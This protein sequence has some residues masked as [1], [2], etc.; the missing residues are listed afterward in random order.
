M[1]DKSYVI[2]L[3]VSAEFDKEKNRT[4]INLSK[5]DNYESRNLS[6]EN[7]LYLLS[8]AISVLIKS[9]DSDDLGYKSHELMEMAIK[10]LENNFIDV[11]AFSDSETVK[12]KN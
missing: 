6:V 3:Q 7:S 11:K 12:N 9:A 2:G 10:R 1:E 8:D 4:V 5:L